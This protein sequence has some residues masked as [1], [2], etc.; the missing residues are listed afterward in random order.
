MGVGGCGS[1]GSSTGV[2]STPAPTTTTASK[3]VKETKKEATPTGPSACRGKTPSAVKEEFYAEAEESLTPEQL[4]AI[5]QLGK[6]EAL[7]GYQGCVYA[8]AQGFA[9]KKKK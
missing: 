2:A 7:A 9:P 4:K 5:G 3:P 6:F 1:G 8:L